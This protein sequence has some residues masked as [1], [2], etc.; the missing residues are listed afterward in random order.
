MLTPETPP[1][2][3][4]TL[5]TQAE[6]QGFDFVA[7]GEHVLFHVPTPNAFVVLA[8]VAARTTRVRLLTA[9]TVVPLYPA[10]LLAK[11]AA[12][13]D[14][15]AAGRL[16]L[17]VGAGGEYPPEFAGCGVSTTE[18]GA[19]LDESLQ[20]CK[21]L[22][23]GEELT[24]DGRFAS[25]EG[26]RLMPTPAG[27]GGP[28]IWVGGRSEASMRRAA[29]FGDYWFPY[30]V[31]PERLAS[32]LERVADAASEA[33]R[34][35][36]AVSGAIFAWAAVDRNAGV[37]RRSAYDS[38]ARIYHQ[39]FERLPASY[40]PQGTPDQVAA[41]LGEYI[42]AGAKSVLF[43]PACAPDEIGAMAELFAHEVMPQLRDGSAAAV[44][45][46]TD[47]KDGER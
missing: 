40:V 43:S 37:A 42:D 26:S 13:L 9:L 38:L 32:G 18:R 2:L 6:S 5:A 22:F 39:D 16:D 44:R 7:C 14:L 12:T 31:S 28:P 24:F 10:G 8:A 15:I 41:H 29:R 4:V 1:A 36:D 17:G 30:M 35:Q 27:A 11:M 45:D 46:T 23:A 33:G 21:R 20:I 3:A 34:P 47:Y 19:R 25:F